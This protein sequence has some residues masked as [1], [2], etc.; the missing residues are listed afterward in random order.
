MMQK[1]ISRGR[2]DERK[3]K[4]RFQRLWEESETLSGENAALE[5]ALDALAL[6]IG[7]EVLPAQQD[8]GNAI[9]Q[10]VDRQLDLNERKTLLQWQR[11]ELRQWTDAHVSDLLAMGLLD[12]R[13]RDRLA[14]REAVAL[15]IELD[16][17]SKLSAADQLE[18]HFRDA[19]RVRDQP[20]DEVAGDRDDVLEQDFDGENHRGGED[21]DGWSDSDSVE[22]L[23]RRMYDEAGQDTAPDH[24]NPGRPVAIDDSVFKRLFRQTAAALHP[25]KEH[26][27]QLQVEKHELMSQLLKARKE[28]DLIS[29][30]RLH[31]RHAVA[32]SSLSSADEKRLEGVL[33]QSIDEQ[34]NRMDDIIRKSPMHY[35]AF[36]QFYDQQPSV[37]ELNIASHLQQIDRKKHTMLDFV[38]EVR[39][40][41]R[42][43]E[44]LRERYD[45]YQS[46]WL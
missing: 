41:K 31:E 40:L 2:P 18:R 28:R 5:I 27:A 12:D 19:M 22:E 30:L 4:T 9:R 8:M 23:F 21:E 11:K 6:R 35:L 34:H 1:S 32:D 44:L 20:V 16:P 24:V 45:A 37:V 26:D 13:L 10:V 25:D 7:S 38:D 39:T 3:R 36:S 15:G 14:L 33:L 46:N 29:L 42:L 43:K 17:Q